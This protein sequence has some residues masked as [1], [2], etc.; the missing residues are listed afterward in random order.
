[1]S[2][3]GSERAGMNAGIGDLCA[4]MDA[5]GAYEGGGGGGSLGRARNL[6]GESVGCVGGALCRDWTTST[7]CRSM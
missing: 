4:C 5:C 3:M 2:A 1:M 7:G 6:S